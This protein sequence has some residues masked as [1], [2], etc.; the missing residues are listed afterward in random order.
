LHVDA[1]PICSTLHTRNELEMSLA[2]GHALELAK[3]RMKGRNRE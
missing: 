3:A 2:T 1:M